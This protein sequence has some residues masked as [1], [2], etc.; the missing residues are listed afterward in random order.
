M[1]EAPLVSVVIPAYNAA[2]WLRRAVASVCQ[3]TTHDW[4]IVLIDDG[5]TDDTPVIIKE[6]AHDIGERMRS[7]RQPQA[8]SSAAR[9]RGIEEARGRFIAFLDADDEFLSHKL[10]RQLAM[11]ARRPELGLVFGDYAYVDL[12]GERQ[13]SAF[14]TKCRLP[15]LLPVEH[16]GESDKICPPDLFN[17][18]LHEYFISTITGLVRRDMLG[19]TI[20]F[21]EGVSYA[22]EWLFY[23]KVSR[24]CRCGFVDEA[25]CLHH[26]VQGSLSRTDVH[27]NHVRLRAL[28]RRMK[29]ELSP[30]TGEQR[31]VLDRH[32]AR[33]N[34]QLGYDLTRRGAHREGAARFLEAAT[35]KGSTVSNLLRAGAASVRSLGAS[36]GVQDR[37]EFVR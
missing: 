29:D 1:T 10:E 4:E 3:Q 31:A 13:P 23:L 5:S 17:W 27:G 33:I 14:D 36:P 32:L 15:R 12:N 18:L 34:T 2:Q 26:H 25:L 8:G 9:N 30:L 28:L 35:H 16:V 24:E 19:S 6:L 21:P 22:E 20:R 11:F 37:S 7:L